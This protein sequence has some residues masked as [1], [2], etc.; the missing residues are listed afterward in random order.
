MGI[1]KTCHAAGEPV[2]HNGR[3]LRCPNCWARWEAEAD[4][5][6]PPARQ[7]PVVDPPSGVTAAPDL[8][9]VVSAKKKQR[10]K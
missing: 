3:G 2:N 5:P 4:T 1:C 8:G 6:H 10:G 9:A 7:A